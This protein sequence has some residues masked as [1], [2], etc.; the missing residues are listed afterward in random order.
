MSSEQVQT[1]HVSAYYISDDT[2]PLLQQVTLRWWHEASTGEYQIWTDTGLPAQLGGAETTLQGALQM[3]QASL[4]PHWVL[5][6]A[7]A[8]RDAWHVGEDCPGTHVR[9]FPDSA[10]TATAQVHAL[11]PLDPQHEQGV[12]AGEY[13]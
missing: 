6:V 4:A 1:V 12:L 8:R 5:L 11:G 10:D 7:G 9:L 3:L 2:E 13:G